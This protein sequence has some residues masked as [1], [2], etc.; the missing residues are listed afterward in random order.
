MIVK[1]RAKREQT[2]PVCL[3]TV[4]KYEKVESVNTQNNYE[5]TSE[6]RTDKKKKTSSVCFVK[7]IKFQ[8][9]KFKIVQNNFQEII[10]KKNSWKIHQSQ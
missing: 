5:T 6:K 2:H 1:Q 8:E 10:T 7:V 3:H 4:Q 9:N